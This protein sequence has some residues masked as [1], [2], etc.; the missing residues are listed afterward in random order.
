MN[1]EINMCSNTRSFV[2]NAPQHYKTDSLHVAVSV[3]VIV[4]A[5]Q[6]LMRRFH[7]FCSKVK[8]E[9]TEKEKIRERE[10]EKGQQG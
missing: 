6:S 9:T 8:P 10:S 1:T 2:N 5:A 4:F 7:C 3:E